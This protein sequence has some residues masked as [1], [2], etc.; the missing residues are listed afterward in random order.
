MTAC[1]YCIE[2]MN[3]EAELCRFCGAWPDTDETRHQHYDTPQSNDVLRL[4]QL[5]NS[6]WC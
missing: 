4:R 2:E 6:S 3:D 1:P 5:L